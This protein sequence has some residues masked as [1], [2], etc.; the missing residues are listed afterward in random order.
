MECRAHDHRP[1]GKRGKFQKDHP[2]RKFAFFTESATQDMCN[3]VP[4]RVTGA[5]DRLAQESFTCT[6]AICAHGEHATL[7]APRT[8]RAL[9]VRPGVEPLSL[10]FLTL[11]VCLLSTMSTG[12]TCVNDP[13]ASPPESSAQ[14]RLPQQSQWRAYRFPEHNL[15]VVSKQAVLKSGDGKQLD[16]EQKAAS[17]EST[18]LDFAQHFA[19]QQV[20]LGCCLFWTQERS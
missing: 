14:R 4:H 8:T 15:L 7:T 2:C 12:W 1:R 13:R 20:R 18:E 5:L 16:L 19:Q 11:T 9:G 3:K 10:V 6:A 17:T